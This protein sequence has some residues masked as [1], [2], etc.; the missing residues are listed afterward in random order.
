MI[1][2]IAKTAFENMA[3]EYTQLLDRFYPAKDS[4]GFTERN[5]TYRFCK[6][7]EAALVQSNVGACFSWM[8]FPLTKQKKE[9][10]KRVSAPH[11]DSV[12]FVFHDDQISVVYIEAKRITEN[13]YDQKYD[14]IISDI[15]RMK[16][17]SNR[18][19]VLEQ[20][21]H[22]A[23]L[24]QKNEYICFAADVWIGNKKRSHEVP[25]WWETALPNSIGPSK[26]QMTFQKEI[27]KYDS[28]SY[29][30]LGLIEEI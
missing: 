1:L 26:Q 13:N 7:F 19:S 15:R 9:N 29:N 11:L 14:S 25:G 6:T 3:I 22:K 2:R 30:L 23:S 24:S 20:V 27:K 17:E 8:E 10:G 4:S 21:Y 5:L 18:A 16:S 28:S 12:I